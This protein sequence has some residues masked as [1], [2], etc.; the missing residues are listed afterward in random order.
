MEVSLISKV[1]KEV[2]FQ[3]IADSIVDDINQNTK[4]SINLESV[5]KGFKFNKTL[6]SNQKALCTI[7]EFK[8]D[9]IISIQY[10]SEKML[11]V[12]TYTFWPNDE[13]SEIR[14]ASENYRSNGKEMSVMFGLKHQAKR[15][16]IKRLKQVEVFALDKMKGQ[17]VD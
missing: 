13:G 11:S 16:M 14:F 4:K 7:L 10:K 2:F 1:T 12:I 17:S 3:V 15:N 6:V 9:E 5:K 8:K